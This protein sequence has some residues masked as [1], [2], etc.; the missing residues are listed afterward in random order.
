MRR[1]GEMGERLPDPICLFWGSYSRTDLKQELN[2]LAF[3]Y[4]DPHKPVRAAVQRA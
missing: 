2:W 4:K 1:P 3:I